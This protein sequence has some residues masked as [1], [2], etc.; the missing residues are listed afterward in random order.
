MSASP[1]VVSMLRA[2]QKAS[3]ATMQLVETLRA[4]V[5]ETLR[6]RLNVMFDGADDLLFE[7]AERATNNQ[8]RRLFFD[9]MRAVRLG[10]KNMATQFGDIYTASF[11]LP[12]VQGVSPVKPVEE[13]ELSLQKDDALDLDIAVQN[14][15]TK[16]EGLYKTTL[17]DINGRLKSLIEDLYAPMSPDALAPATICL[18]FRK[19]A[20]TLNIGHDVELVVFKLFDRLVISELADLYT[21]ILNFLKLNGVRSSQ[22]AM[23]PNRS[24]GGG[25]A[26]E[27][28][29]ANETVTGPSF[30]A[31]PPSFAS[32]PLS[33]SSAPQPE[34]RAPVGLAASMMMSPSFDQQTLSSLQRL[35]ASAPSHAGYSN[36]SLAADLAAASQGQ[37]IV[38]WSPRQTTAYVQRASLVGH[39]FNEFLADPHLPNS[40]RPQFDGLRM[41]TMKVALKDIAFVADPDHPVRGLINELATMAS[42][43]KVGGPMHMGRIAELVQQIQK[44]F[45]VAAETLRKPPPEIELIG[46]DQAERFIEQQMAQTAARR[47][48]IVKKV[49]RIIAEE[50]QLR[51]RG[52]TISDEVRPLLNSL[53]AP[54]MAMH[55]LHHGPDSVEWKR[56][57]A[58][59]D[60]VLAMLDP[61]QEELRGDAQVQGLRTEL[62]TA[63]KA[64]GLAEARVTA[65]LNGFESTLKTIKSGSTAPDPVLDTLSSPPVNIHASTDPDAKENVTELLEQLVQPGSWFLIFD[66]DRGESRWMKAVA[67]YAGL[68]CAAF[69]EF[70]GSNTLLLKSRM[71]LEDLLARRTVPVDLGPTARAALDRYLARAA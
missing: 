40:M 12:N 31:P 19:A 15:A 30:G 53:W 47:A 2:K 18:A 16:A 1:K 60:R 34:F 62:E 64:V 44:Q 69:A 51:T 36:A 29:A 17:W 3:E 50:L 33:G 52:T 23:A 55:L 58:S 42:T 26:D 8:D 67:Y 14:M 6:E 57:I 21:K 59:L 24:G 20:E 28:P 37:P 41:S 27:A 39:M 25:G 56:G 65:A 68:D 32:A 38:G 63:F 9:T 46:T 71:L 54:M 48:S 11:G 5:V 7:F 13:Q 61:A 45:D 35:G 66:P 43:A 10:R 22:A 49:R 4:Q 70:N